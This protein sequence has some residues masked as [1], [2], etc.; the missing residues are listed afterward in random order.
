MPAC[1][2]TRLWLCLDLGA[3]GYFINAFELV[4][5]L[6]GG[7]PEHQ[8][9]LAGTQFD[10]LKILIVIVLSTG[11]SGESVSGH[12]FPWWPLQ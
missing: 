10:N 3:L 1:V 6:Q 2:L 8:F 7:S 4:K 9:D 5:L 12:D 11:R